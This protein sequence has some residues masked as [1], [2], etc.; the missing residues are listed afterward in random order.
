MEETSDLKVLADTFLDAMEERRRDYPVFR[1]YIS[2]VLRRYEFMRDFCAEVEALRALAKDA[3]EPPARCIGDRVRLSA[4]RFTLT[5][6]ELKQVQDERDRLGARFDTL[7]DIRYMVEHIG[8][9][10]A[11]VESCISQMRGRRRLL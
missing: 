9:T 6:A 7:N 10:S 5:D 1:E 11:T 2:S 3:P 4:R 8:S